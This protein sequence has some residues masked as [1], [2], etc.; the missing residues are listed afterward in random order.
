MKRQSEG[1]EWCWLRL[2]FLLI[3]LLGT[4]CA[5]EPQEAV[6]VAPISTPW[7]KFIDIATILSALFAAVAAS[8]LMLHRRRYNVGL[9][10]LPETV[11]V[12][13]GGAA[14]EADVVVHARILPT[15]STA[16]QLSDSIVLKVGRKRFRAKR[17]WERDEDESINFPFP[18]GSQARIG[19]SFGLEK[20]LLTNRRHARLILRD[21]FSRKRFKA[22]IALP[23]AAMQVDAAAGDGFSK[24]QANPIAESGQEG[25]EA[26]GA[27]NRTSRHGA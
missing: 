22:R 1:G 26:G 17:I 2:F 4:A 13:E 14:G 25:T 9:V 16:P 5:T 7:T 21:A 6:P 18:V 3:C 15:K 20:Q 8:G 23:P 27:E 24:D 10:I 11:T 19:I 12:T